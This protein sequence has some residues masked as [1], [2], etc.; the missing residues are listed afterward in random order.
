MADFRAGRGKF[1]ISQEH[2]VMPEEKKDSKP[3]G[4]SQEQGK[5]LLLAKHRAQR[6][7]INKWSVPSL[8]HEPHICRCN[9][10]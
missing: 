9:R 8:P 1:K 3:M 5:E 6:T 4:M 2:V 10:P 7:K